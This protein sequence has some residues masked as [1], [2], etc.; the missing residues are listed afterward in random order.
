ME[1]AMRFIVQSLSVCCLL[2]TCSS[3]ASLSYELGPITLVSYPDLPHVEEHVVTGT[4]T[5]NGT[6]GRLNSTDFVSWSISVDGSRPYMFHPG[7]PGAE[8]ISGWVDAS[9]TEITA[10]GQFGELFIR[11]HDNTIP[12]CTD[13]AQWLK[14][15][16]WGFGQLSYLHYDRDDYV[17]TFHP[18][19]VVVD[20]MPFV[21]AS[22]DVAEPPPGDFN[23]NGSV[24]AADYVVWRNR[25]GSTHTPADFDMWRA[26]FGKAAV[27]AV[28]P[29]TT[30]EPATW[31]LVAVAGSLFS[32]RR[33]TLF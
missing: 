22:R 25:L 3:A 20:Q 14:W 21:I 23:R 27:S 24:D 7:N 17:P 10:E 8:V 6:I 9:L 28:A 15:S 1:A 18:G 33:R 12:N 32:L 16:G 2:V 4:I 31:L 11:A 19:N 13:C 29:S 26:N 5:T 30:P